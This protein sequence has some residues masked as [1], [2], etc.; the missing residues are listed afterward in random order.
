MPK[1]FEP[2]ST[3]RRPSKI[4][5]GYGFDKYWYPSSATVNKV[6]FA[7]GVTVFD[8]EYTV[9]FVGTAPGIYVTV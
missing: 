4:T 7:A 1:T 9:V 6:L 2:T 5:P 3:W 8:V